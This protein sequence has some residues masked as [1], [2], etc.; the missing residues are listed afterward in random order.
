MNLPAVY[1]VVPRAT[2]EPTWPSASV[3]RSAPVLVSKLNTPDLGVPSIVAVP[4]KY[5]FE[6]MTTRPA[7]WLSYPSGFHPLS[8]FVCVS[9]EARPPRGW[10]AIPVNV[11]AT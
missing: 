11:P 4:A 8:V 1:S 9:N 2:S 6:P 3:P 10:P 5:N 7:G